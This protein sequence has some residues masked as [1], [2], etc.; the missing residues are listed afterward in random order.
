MNLQPRPNLTELALV[1]LKLGTIGFGGPVA[2]IAMLEAEIV[3]RRQWLSQERFV[4]LLG[5]TN[6]LPGPSSTELAIY[7]GY[8]RAGWLG[9]IIAGVCFILPAMAIVWGLAI[10]YERFQTVPQAIAMFAGVKPV[11]IVLTIMA[12]W[13]LGRSALKNIPTRIAG[14]LAIGLGGGFGLNPLI[15]AGRILGGLVANV[16]SITNSHFSSNYV[17]A[18]MGD[19]I[20][21]FPENRCDDLWRWVCV[22]GFSPTGIGRT[23]PL[24]DLATVTRCDRDRASYTRATVHY[25]NLYRLSISWAS[26]RDRCHCRDFLT[27]LHFRRPSDSLGTAITSLDLGWELVGWGQCGSLGGDRGGNISTWGHYTGRLAND[28]DC[29]S[30]LAAALAMADRCHLA[31]SR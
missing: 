4:D 31:D 12:T 28:L 11:V 19:C 1:F 18:I 6:L 26:W 3:T 17:S 22:A 7:I 8:L 24:V 5:V 13:K 14:I 21:D 25:G 15:V 9:L 16:K 30:Q 20:W 2:H 23:Y 29:R 27:W 10:G